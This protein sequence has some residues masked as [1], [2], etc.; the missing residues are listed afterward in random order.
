MD[1]CA[2]VLVSED[3]PEVPGNGKAG[4]EITLGR[5]EG[6]GGRG[7]LEEEEGEEDKDLGPDT[8]VVVEGVDTEGNKG[9]KDD[10]DG[11]PA[12]V[13]REGEVD[14]DFVSGIGGL[15]V[16]L[17]NVVDVCDRRR[18]EEREDES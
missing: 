7:G 3:G 17:N 6:V 12:V 14:K 15:V 4:G 11:S 13:E 1:E 9:G 10:K 5:G 2:A 16:L 18:Y 8:C